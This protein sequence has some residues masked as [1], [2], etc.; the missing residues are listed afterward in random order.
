MTDNLKQQE[1]VESKVSNGGSG[2]AGTAYHCAHKHVIRLTAC[3]AFGVPN[4][5]KRVFFLA[6]MHGD[7]RDV[8][9]AQVRA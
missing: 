6:S 7:A 3:A 4:R 1:A 8:L 9:L 2:R 5:R